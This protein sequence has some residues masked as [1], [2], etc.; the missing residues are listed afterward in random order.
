MPHCSFCNKQI[1]SELSLKAHEKFCTANP[2]AQPRPP[3][4]PNA[5]RKKGCVSPTK[6]FKR[7]EENI[8]YSE[9][10]IW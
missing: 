2:N 1:G 4:S 9:E 5:G 6:G 8:Q 10:L 7:T 3:R